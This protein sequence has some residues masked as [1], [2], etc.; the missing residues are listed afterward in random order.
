M[1]L[2]FRSNPKVFNRRV[3]CYCGRYF[4][5]HVTGEEQR[6]ECPYCKSILKV[7]SQLEVAVDMDVQSDECTRVIAEKIAERNKRLEEQGY[8]G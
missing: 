7:T 8:D 4:E 5:L 1:S 6:V 3:G 2:L